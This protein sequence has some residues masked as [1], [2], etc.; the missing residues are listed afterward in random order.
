VA[1]SPVFGGGEK[2]GTVRPATIEL[3]APE[4]E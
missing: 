1:S 2:V 3:R 4:A